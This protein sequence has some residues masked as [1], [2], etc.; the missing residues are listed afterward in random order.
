LR[1][2]LLTKRSSMYALPLTSQDRNKREALRSHV[3]ARQFGSMHGRKHD[4]VSCFLT[5]GRMQTGIALLL[6]MFTTH[7]SSWARAQQV[8]TSLPLSQRFTINL[9]AGVP[10]Y[11]G[12]ATSGSNA[13]QSQWWFENTNNSTAY[14]STGF[15]ESTDSAATWRQVGLPTTRTSRAPTS[16]RLPAAARAL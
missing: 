5:R 3:V 15:V 13:P 2:D 7:C 16:T 14:S 6:L 8:E 4:P 9:A 10:E 12:N 1:T 11:I